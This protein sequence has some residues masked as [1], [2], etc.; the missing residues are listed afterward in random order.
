MMSRISKSTKRSKTLYFWTYFKQFPHFLTLFLLFWGLNF[1]V[2][3]SGHYRIWINQN[4]VFKNYAYP[5][6]WRNNLLEGGEQAQPPPLC[7]RGT[8]KF[9]ITDQIGSSLRLKLPWELVIS[10]IMYAQLLFTSSQSL[11]R[12]N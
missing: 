2:P 1:N 9:C 5:K 10:E 3:V 7:K 11:N 4:F 12:T 6:L 8:N